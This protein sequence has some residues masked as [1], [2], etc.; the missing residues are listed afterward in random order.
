MKKERRAV[1]REREGGGRSC[2][3]LLLLHSSLPCVLLCLLL[4]FPVELF[5]LC[6]SLAVLFLLFPGI[7]GGS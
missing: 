4:P 1:E 6:Y 5:L 7:E 3:L 2:S